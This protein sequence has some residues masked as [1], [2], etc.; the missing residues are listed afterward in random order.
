MKQFALIAAISAVVIILG[1]S[2]YAV[3]A[4]AGWES[5]PNLFYGMMNWQSPRSPAGNMMGNYWSNFSYGPNIIHRNYSWMMQ[6]YGSMMHSI[7]TQKIQLS[8]A[9][10]LMKVIPSYAVI[11]SAYDTI[12]FS[13]VNSK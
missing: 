12:R 10:V 13:R 5:R 9:A 11:S 2:L 7:G 8:Q 6:N 4:Y 3:S 1:V